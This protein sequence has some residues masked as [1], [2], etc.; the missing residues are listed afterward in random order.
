MRLIVLALL[1]IL[2]SCTAYRTITEAA[3]TAKSMA[4]TSKQFLGQ[5]EKLVGQGKDVLVQVQAD[6]R[7]HQVAADADKDGSTTSEEW[8]KY[9]LGPAGVGALAAYFIRNMK[10]NQRKSDAEARL[11]RLENALE[12]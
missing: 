5:A 3:E 4:A 6:Y 12:E 9:L 7:K 1:A 11:A 8:L 2:P 10:S